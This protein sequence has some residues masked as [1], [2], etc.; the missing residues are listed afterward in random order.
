MGVAVG[1]LM[2][3]E[4]GGVIGCDAGAEEV[5]CCIMMITTINHSEASIFLLLVNF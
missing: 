5:C 3:V 4:E 2:A 1:D